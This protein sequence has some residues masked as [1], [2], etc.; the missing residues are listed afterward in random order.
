MFWG[1]KF[2]SPASLSLNTSVPVNSGS[3]F[4]SQHQLPSGK[5]FLTPR[6][7]YV[8]F[9]LFLHR[10]IIT[11]TNNHLPVMCYY[12]VSPPP[13]HRTLWDYSP[14]ISGNELHWQI[15]SAQSILDE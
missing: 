9:V 7:D 1:G 5:S 8:L 4:R 12:Y 2:C 11:V 14:N 3:A 10:E 13:D 15:V 6:P